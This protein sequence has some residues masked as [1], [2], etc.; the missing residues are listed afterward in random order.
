MKVRRMICLVLFL[1]VGF[2]YI[3]E[4]HPARYYS[5]GTASTAGTWYI[6]GAGF[7]SH[8]NKRAPDIKITAEITLG[9][10][11]NY[12][13]IK[14]GKLDFG[15]I[16]PNFAPDDIQKGVISSGEKAPFRQ[17]IWGHLLNDFHWFV[18]KESPIKTLYDIKGK[19]LSIGPHGSGG[20]AK[21]LRIIKAITGYEHKKDYEG[22]Y[23]TY[24]ETIT[25]IKDNTIDMGCFFAAIPIASLIDLTSMKE[26]RF[27]SL[28]E[29]E[30]KKALQDKA[31]MLRKTVIP[32]GTYKGL[33]QDLLTV[34]QGFGIYCRPSIPENDVY[35][36][37][38]AFY[39][40]VEQRFSIHPGAKKFAIE[41]LL[42][43]G[44]AQAEMGIPFHPGVEKYLKE[45]GKWSPKLEVK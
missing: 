16:H 17:V 15:L 18:R 8:I 36:I 37:V 32:K 20:M 30:I 22:L 33:D 26:V 24:P 5:L 7:A 10:E 2:W 40:D 14:R 23:L 4:A 43:T 45:I 29:N 9:S 21:N 41:D 6:L 39:T 28:T 13:L 12:N 27:L 19:K 38:K 1:A 34:G 25:G 3:S 44:A 31:L 35:A 11:E 42:E